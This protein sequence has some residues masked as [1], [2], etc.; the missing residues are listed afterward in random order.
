MKMLSFNK[1]QVIFKQ[2]DCAE[3]MF[4]IVSGRVGIYVGYGTEAE[5]QLTVLEAGQFLG[6]LG[7]IEAYP[8]SATAVAM[9]DA[10]QLREIGEKEF[11]EYFRTQPER[12]LAIMRQISN[13]LRDLT[14]DY[15]AAGLV[16]DGLKQTQSAPERRSKSLLERAKALIALYD[17]AI[18]MYSGSVNESYFYSFHI[19]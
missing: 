3:S 18:Q 5:T 4:D 16:L 17:E 2:G 15:E 14:K 1:D 8:R 12:L 11:D 10:T 6:E 9:E 19:H 7:L 13:R